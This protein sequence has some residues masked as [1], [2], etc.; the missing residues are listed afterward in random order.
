MSGHV[1]RLSDSGTENIEEYLE[2]IYRL[3]LE[4]SPAKTGELA[5]HLLVS[6]PSVSEMLKKLEK[7]GYIEYAPY[8]GA[9]LTP[10]GRRIAHRTLRKH[11]VI[12][13]VLTQIVG[14]E[15]DEAHEW[16][17][18]MEHVVPDELE[19]WLYDQIPEKDLKGLEPPPTEAKAKA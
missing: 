12:Q 3:Q 16:A 9:T 4:G 11:R 19:R 17:C 6:P 5:K 10:A 8:Q 7:M 13:E 15:K 1:S 14:M 2:T 18:R